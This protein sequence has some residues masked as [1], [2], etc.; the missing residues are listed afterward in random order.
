MYSLFY[1]AELSGFMCDC[2]PHAKLRAKIRKIFDICKF[3][4]R[5]MPL[6]AE[7]GRDRQ[8]MKE[9]CRIRSGGKKQSQKRKRPLLAVA[10]RIN[11]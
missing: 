4:C 8:R 10:L 11:L 2:D 7:I 6:Y 3:I 5:N 9:Y 1:A